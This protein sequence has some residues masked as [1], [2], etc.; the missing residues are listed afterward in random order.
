MS[1]WGCYLSKYLLIKMDDVAFSVQA[2]LQTRK[3]IE[4]V[5]E[6]SMKTSFRWMNALRAASLAALALALYLPAMNLPQA[7]AVAAQAD[8]APRLPAGIVLAS[9][10]TSW[11][12]VFA[13]GY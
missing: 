1:L 12:T 6:T 4:P 2:I 13:S 10:K 7:A 5:K 9:A 8:T 3:A 11:N